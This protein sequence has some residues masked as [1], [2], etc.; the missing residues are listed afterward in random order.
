M[1]QRPANNPGGK[2]IHAEV[3]AAAQRLCHSED[4]TFKPSEVVRALPYLNESSVRTHIVSRCCENAPKNHAHRWPYFR[5]LDRGL[6][7]I[8]PAYR[9]TEPA[10]PSSLEGST[11]GSHSDNTKLARQ[12]EH[13]NTQSA[14][15][16]VVSQ[17]EG[18]YVAECLEVAVVTQGR[19]LDETLANLRTAL[20][21]HLDDEELLRTGLPP[22]PRLLAHYEFSLFAS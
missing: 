14:I 7:E 13:G 20:A 10:G 6:Y 3:L 17:S 9:S 4:W 5:R 21:L 16:A 18:W 1:I 2:P 11:V 22:A 12:A 8:L 19:S 15:H